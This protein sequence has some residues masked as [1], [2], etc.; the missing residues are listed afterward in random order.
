[1]IN[2]LGS[3]E[4]SQIIFLSLIGLL[5]LILILCC[6]LRKCFLFIDGKRRFFKKLGSELDSRE[7]IVKKT[8]TKEIIQKELNYVDIL[9]SGYLDLNNIQNEK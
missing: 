9:P 6:C 5:P 1:M 3:F 2:F 8:E 7:I 4:G